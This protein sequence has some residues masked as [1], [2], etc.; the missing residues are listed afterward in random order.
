MKSVA[1]RIHDGVYA[2][3]VVESALEDAFL[4]Y[5]PDNYEKILDSYNLR[6]DSYD[7]SVEIDIHADF[8]YPY[9]P[10]KEIRDKIYALGFSIV[11]WNFKENVFEGTCDEIRGWEPR[12]VKDSNKWVI[13]EYGYVD[14]RFDEKKWL[15]KYYRNK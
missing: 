15:I 5:E 9:E 14:G 6:F 11:Y 1:E 3:Y 8:P 7:N 13:T 4:N 12:H 2:K 10:C